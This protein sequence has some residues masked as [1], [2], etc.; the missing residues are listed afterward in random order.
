[1]YTA[2]LKDWMLG[3]GLIWKKKP[4]IDRLLIREK[5][6][7]PVWQNI[8]FQS[9]NWQ[10]CSSLLEQIVF[11]G[12]FGKPEVTSSLKEDYRQLKKLK[13]DI[14]SS[15]SKLVEMMLAR[16]AILIRNATAIIHT[17]SLSLSACFTKFIR[18]LPSITLLRTALSQIVHVQ[19]GLLRF[20]K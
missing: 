17:N 12:K 5:E 10:H 19:N 4:L 1:M 3:W 9:L 2:L 11:A 14:R 16:E 20:L 6:M 7:L 15:A 13:I 8:A 18:Q